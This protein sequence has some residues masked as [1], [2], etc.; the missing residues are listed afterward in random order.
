MSDRKS[1]DKF[2]AG[3]SEVKTREKTSGLYLATSHEYPCRKEGCSTAWFSEVPAVIISSTSV[4]L[5]L[6]IDIHGR[7]R[8][9]ERERKREPARGRE[10]ARRN[11]WYREV[12][13]GGGGCCTLGGGG[14]P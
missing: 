9:G 5:L 6:L 14:V 4:L 13:N 12:G 3:K 10:T 2:F 1:R 8:D 7:K 11:S